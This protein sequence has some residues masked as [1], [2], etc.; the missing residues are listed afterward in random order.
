MKIEID[1]W[2]E[3]QSLMEHH[4]ISLGSNVSQFIIALMQIFHAKH[5][6]ELEICLDKSIV[7][8]A[9]AKNPWM[10]ATYLAGQ[11]SFPTLQG[12][13]TSRHNNKITIRGA[14]NKI[15]PSFQATLRAALLKDKI[16]KYPISEI[17]LSYVTQ[18]YVIISKLRHTG[19]EAMV[20]HITTK[21]ITY[22][23]RIQSK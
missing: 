1:S 11:V 3:I 20:F 10:W 5:E 22:K 8:G 16:V 23:L 4:S 2:E 14:Y 13:K 15:L 7:P 17:P 19:V 21:H 12:Y 9:Y 18:P 6:Q